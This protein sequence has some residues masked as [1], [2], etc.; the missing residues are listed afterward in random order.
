MKTTVQVSLLASL[1]TSACSVHAV[2]L[3]DDFDLP[4]Y[5]EAVTDYRSRG[6]SQTLNDPALQAGATLSHSSGLYAGI[7][8]S[9]V[10]F[11]S[12]LKTRQEIDYYAGYYW[13]VTDDVGLDV[14]YAKYA[15]E[16]EG[17]L[18]YGESYAILSAYGFKLATQ[19]ADDFGGDQSYNWNW[20]GYETQLPYEV[21]LSL[22][23][24]IVDYKDDVLISSSGNTRQSYDEWVVKASKD[25]AGLTWSL[26]YVDTDISQDE[27]AS[28]LGYDDICSATLVAG[29]K[30]AF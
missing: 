15:Y 27:C 3:N 9:N 12:N 18:N 11:G 30:K 13:Q 14:G 6:Q 16:R 19:Y 28:Y 8:T 10:D 4:V 21:N 17:Q 7:W 24:G 2:T 23:Y 29:V 26:S 22:H 1:L 5:V 20:V 25:F